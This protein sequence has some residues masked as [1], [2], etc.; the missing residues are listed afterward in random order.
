MSMAER[1][2]HNSNPSTPSLSAYMELNCNIPQN[3]LESLKQQKSRW[4]LKTPSESSEALQNH[5]VLLAST[6][7]QQWFA[8][9]LWRYVS[10]EA[11]MTQTT[12]SHSS[13]IFVCQGLWLLIL[14]QFIGHPT[15]V[16]SRWRWMP[17]SLFA[18][19]RDIGRPLC[20]DRIPF[21]SKM[22]CM[23]PIPKSCWSL[24]PGSEGSIALLITIE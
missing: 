21:I 15:P 18:S 17:R 2:I 20:K 1:S 3:L 13:M 24:Y 5:S 9:L 14:F 16:D 23:I 19:R 7:A 22:A 4:S 12:H 6:R 10:S 11:L 8:N